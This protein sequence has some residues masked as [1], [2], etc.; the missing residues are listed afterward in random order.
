MKK[1]IFIIALMQICFGMKVIAANE[2]DCIVK[3]GDKAYIGKDIKMGALHTKLYAMDGTVTK[4]DNRDITAYRHH[5]KMYML[6]PVI[7]EYNDTTCMAMMQYI[8][9][10]ADYSIFKYCCPQNGD[11]FFVYKDDKFYR[12]INCAAA[13]E[14]LT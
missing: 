3:V 2:G 4:F 9:T 6:L 1:T 11:L 7:C 5:D 14:E 8:R 13:K 12:R 10:K